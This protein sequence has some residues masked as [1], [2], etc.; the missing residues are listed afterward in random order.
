MYFR[1][2]KTG[3]YSYVQIA[4]SQREGKAVRQRVLSTLGRLETLK[5][6]GALD[7]LLRSGA[8]LCEQV[9]VID[10]HEEGKTQPVAVR[11]IGPDL[12]FGR[13]WEELG[14]ERVL[15]TLLAER[16]FEFSVERAV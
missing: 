3:A 4:E 7:A 14:I 11:R 6:S 12:V 5:S 8:R 13:L 1:I 10:A 16:G 15:D 9:A 2:K